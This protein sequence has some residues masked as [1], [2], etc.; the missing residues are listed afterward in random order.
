MKVSDIIENF[1]KDMMKEEDSI[2]IKR[3]EM[4]ELFQC[5]PSQINY[6]LTT[7]FSTQRG[8]YIESRRGGGGHIKI[9]R[10]NIKADDFLEKLIQEEISEQISYKVAKNLV[11]NLLERELIS[12]REAKIILATINDRVLNIPVKQLENKIRAD[13]LK[14]VLI[15]LF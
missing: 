4:A 6:V 10:L 13:I 5:S 14:S 8:Y 1:I 7:R 11:I 2:E 12:N 9:I 15:N 3:N